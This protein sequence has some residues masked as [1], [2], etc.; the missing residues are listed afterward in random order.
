MLAVSEL[1]EKSVNINIRA[2]RRQREMI[3][4]AAQLT[5]KTR[6]EFM[7]ETAYQA[8][9][10]TILDQRAFHLDDEQYQRFI[11]TLEAPPKTNPKLRDLLSRKAPWAK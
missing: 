9:E 8:A 11:D 5:G 1:D 2:S 10:D 3:D 6:T 7:L 4:R